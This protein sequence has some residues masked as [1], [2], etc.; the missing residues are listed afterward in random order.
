MSKEVQR[1][2]PW[3]WARFGRAPFGSCLPIFISSS[4][5]KAVDALHMK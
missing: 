3:V 4:G 5:E 2:L 1:E